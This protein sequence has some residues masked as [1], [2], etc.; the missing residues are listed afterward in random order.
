ME[1]RHD[2]DARDRLLERVLVLAGDVDD[3]LR[4]GRESRLPWVGR[5][6][7]P[8]HRRQISIEMLHLGARKGKTGHEGH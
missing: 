2:L 5:V 4:Q 8:D 6:V 7:R 3:S 1:D